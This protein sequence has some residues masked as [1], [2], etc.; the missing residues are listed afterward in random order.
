MQEAGRAGHQAGSNI[1]GRCLLLYCNESRESNMKHILTGKVEHGGS[2]KDQEEAKNRMQQV[3]RYCENV[4]LCRVKKLQSLVGHRQAFQKNC[5]RCDVCKPPDN[6]DSITVVQDAKRV[7]ELFRNL[8]HDV[9]FNKK[10]VG[11][12]TRDKI[13]FSQAIHVLL[14]RHFNDVPQL[15]QMN[16]FGKCM[17]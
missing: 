3:T 4:S 13:T 15:S 6:R 14:G 10:N 5:N 12:T 16:Q 11:E 1:T 17:S 8:I 2:P 9:Q 7:R